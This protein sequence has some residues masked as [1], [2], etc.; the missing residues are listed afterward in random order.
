MST[1]AE[2]IKIILVKRQKSIKELSK[3]IGISPNSMY[4]KLKA[5]GKSFKISELE[6]IATALNCTLTTDFTLNDTQE[7]F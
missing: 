6:S 2:S 5:D 3:E 4:S 7:K 1:I